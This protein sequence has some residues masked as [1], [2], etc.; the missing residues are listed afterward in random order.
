MKVLDLGRTDYL[1]TLALQL[2]LFNE[3]QKAISNEDYLIVTEHKP[4]YT[5]G[6]TTKKEHILDTG[7]IPAV[8]IERGGSITFHGYGQIVVYPIIDLRNRKNTS[9]KNYIW[10][11]EEG[12]I[13]TL[14]EFDIKGYRI[15]GKRGVFTEKGKIGF[16][17]VRVSRYITMHGISLNV[18]VD[19]EFFKRIVP[20]GIDNIPICNLQDFKNVNYDTVKKI[21]V[22][23]L[24]S[25]L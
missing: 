14:E 3:K 23:K 9:V 15:E 20:C 21:L 24:L 16:I 4:V 10:S 2:L 22:E 11:L 5:L 17:G 25:V 18:N 12:I 19:K 13:R 7:N 8:E 1:Q 6:K